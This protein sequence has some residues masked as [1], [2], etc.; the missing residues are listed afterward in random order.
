MARRVTPAPAEE[1]PGSN[2]DGP[3]PA[4]F[5]KHYREYTLA[6]RGIAEANSVNQTVAKRA[7]SDGVDVDAMK[8]TYKRGKKER[9]VVTQ[10]DSTVGLYEHMLGR[11]TQPGLFDV[12]PA[13]AEESDMEFASEIE[14]EQEGYNAGLAGRDRDDHRFAAGALTAISF[15]RGHD[16]GVT[17]IARGNALASQ[18]STAA[19]RKR[20]NGAGAAR[21]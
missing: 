9:D 7:K 10:H 11:V 8:E 14:A 6:Q 16:A 17:F 15:L 4:V 18:V 13:E 1:R 2:G 20:G 3:S 19:P 21:D 5:L 12:E